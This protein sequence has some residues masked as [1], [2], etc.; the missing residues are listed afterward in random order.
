MI[1]IIRKKPSAIRS[2]EIQYRLGRWGLQQVSWASAGRVFNLERLLYRVD[3][4]YSHRDGWRQSGSNRF[5]VAPELTWL[6]APR[7]RVT[8]IQTI[9]RDRFTLD[10]GVPAALLAIRSLPL[11]R[12]LNPS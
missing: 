9:T 1:N 12:R 10:A 3:A 5:T 4:S 2:N 7:V 11:D 6:I 8:A